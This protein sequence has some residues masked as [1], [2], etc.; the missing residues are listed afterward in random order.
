MA[1]FKRC[2]QLPGTG[3]R[4]HQIDEASGSSSAGL[5][6]VFAYVILFST[7]HFCRFHSGNDNEEGAALC[8]DSRL[9]A[10]EMD[11]DF[12]ESSGA[13]EEARSQRCVLPAC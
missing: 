7:T 12:R 8:S 2:L 3:R 10:V 5:A 9:P 6:R 11:A 1:R 4:Q 13:P